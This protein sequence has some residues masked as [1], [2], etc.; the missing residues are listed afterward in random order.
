MKTI[1]MDNS[2]TAQPCAAAI[3]ALEASVGRDW[4]NPSAAYGAAAEVEKELSGVRAL[5]A[6]ELGAAPAGVVFTSGGTEADSLAIL[7]SAAR[8]RGSRRVL[9][10]AG[11]HPAVLNTRAQLERMGHE[12]LLIPARDDGVP[13]M[14]ALAE[15][16]DE[17]TALVSIMQVNNETGAVAPL[18]EAVRIVRARSP[19]ALI[20]SDGVQGF[21]R[22]P[23]LPERLGIDLYTFSGHKIHGIK[24][25]GALAM[26]AGVRLL[27]RVEGGGQE[28]GLR[29][30]TENTPGICA[31]GAAVAWMRG[32]PE[33]AQTLRAVKLRLYEAL[34]A[35]VEGLRVN[36]P[37][38]CGEDAAPHILNVS[39]PDVRGEVML[40]ALEAE[41]VL[42]GTGSACSSKKR[43]MKPAFEAMRA[44]RWAAES[45]VRFSLGM[46]NTPEE[47][48]AAAE[49]AVRC[50]QRYRKFV[51]R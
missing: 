16:C 11:E 17:R 46:F 47:A 32:Q 5:I 25:T 42:V 21:L 19:E 24:G 4:Y 31:M 38:P 3:S 14:D 20:H 50:W 27:P 36:G 44:P 6:Q 39:F 18:E 12:V 40:H 37:D 43:G 35:G 2:A 33:R 48:D 49:A 41:G 1:Y 15:L 7:G 30:G 34:R 29:S 8:F 51:R 22:V 28:K 13:D 26:R 10:F 23:V 45:A 9:M